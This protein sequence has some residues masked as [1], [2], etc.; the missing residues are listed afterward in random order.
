MARSGLNRADIERVRNTLI[1]LGKHPSVDAVRIGLGNTGSKTTIHRHLKALEAEGRG[2]V[3]IALSDTLQDLVGRLAA[4]LREEAEARIAAAQAKLDAER[5]GFVAERDAK[6]ALAA[7]LEASLKQLEGQLAAEQAEHGCARDAI[8]SQKSTLD[9]IEE[10]AAGLTARLAEAEVHLQSLEAK[11][12]HAREALEHFRTAAKEQR[13]QEIRRHEHEVQGLQVELRRAQE[14]NARATMEVLALTRSNVDFSAQLEIRG[15]DFVER[16]ERI[17]A[18]QASL[19]E[20]A[21]LARDHPTLLAQLKAVQQSE[22]RLAAELTSCASQLGEERIRAKRAEEALNIQIGRLEGMEA[23]LASSK[24]GKS[25]P[26][27]GAAGSLTKRTFREA[28]AAG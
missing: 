27:A 24:P 7:S 22:T 14:A 25:L 21:P 13:D 8:A 5:Q 17:Q 4:Q 10:R 3:P 9:R 28:L 6:A 16:G 15:R 23:A 2:P 26:R 18:L 20:A 1:A 19:E 11:H 12:R